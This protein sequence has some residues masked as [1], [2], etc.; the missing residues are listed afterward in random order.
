MKHQDILKHNEK[1]WGWMVRNK[2]RWTVPVNDE[3]IK[4]ARKGKFE[5]SLSP[6]TKN[7]AH[8]LGDVSG[9]KI[10]GLAAGGGQTEF[11]IS[12]SGS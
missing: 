2:S 5:I 7:P 6:K 4:S 1:A 9:K 11:C 8:W 10:L 12:G 3:V